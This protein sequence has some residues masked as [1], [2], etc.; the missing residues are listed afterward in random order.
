MIATIRRSAELL[1]FAASV[2]VAVPAL[3][4]GAKVVETDGL[5]RLTICRSWL[6]FTSCQSYNHIAIPTRVTVGDTIELIFGS[7]T[8]KIRYPIA[9]IAQSGKSCT[10]YNTTPP[11]P[12]KKVDRIVAPCR[13]ATP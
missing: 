1:L 2:V 9:S 7:N 11:D 13:A 6:F 4:A 3:A 12:D 5:G 10:I 8:K